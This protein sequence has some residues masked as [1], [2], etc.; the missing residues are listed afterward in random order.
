MSVFRV[1]LNNNSQ[2]LLDLDPST[3]AGNGTYGQLGEAFSTNNPNSGD[4]SLQRQ[5]YVMGPGKINRLLVDGATFSDCNYWKR[6]T[7]AETS[8]EFSFIEIVTDDGSVYSDIAA[9]N[10]FVVGETFTL[11][12][13]FNSTNLIDFVATH[14]GPAV[15]L[16]VR[17]NDGAI[18]ITGELNGDAN[19]TFTLGGGEVQV[20]NSNDL[21]I[22]QIRLLSA[23]GTPVAEVL[24]SVRSVCTS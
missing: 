22:T 3:N 21:A 10:T 2:G 16:Q 12:T 4:Y 24:A 7:P 17:N 5:V 19:V 11:A 13:T 18:D 8:E 6:F 14:G 15:F 1:N 23:S 9:E 20:F